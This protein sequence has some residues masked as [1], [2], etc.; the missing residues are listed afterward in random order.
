[1]SLVRALHSESG[2]VLWQDRIQQEGPWASS[3][4]QVVFLLSGYPKTKEAWASLLEHERPRHPQSSQHQPVWEP[5]GDLCPPPLSPTPVSEDIWDGPALVELAADT[6]APQTA[7]TSCP[8]IPAW[9][10]PG[11]AVC[12]LHTKTQP[13]VSGVLVCCG[14]SGNTELLMPRKQSWEQKSQLARRQQEVQGFASCRSCLP[15]RT[16]GLC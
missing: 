1:M 10:Q 2:L 15:L 12:H 11:A 16:C 3:R 6:P 13:R 4:M 8:A 5:P 9:S 7:E 14:S